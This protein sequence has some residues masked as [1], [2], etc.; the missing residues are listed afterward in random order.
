MEIHEAI[1]KR[2]SVRSY[3]DKSIPADI[4]SQ[5]N[6]E[7]TECNRESG[8]H[9][10]LVTG[11][12]EAF[13][14][15]M[16]HYGKF[17]GV[18]N[19]IALIGRKTADLDEK[20]GYYGERIAIKAQQLGLNTCW[21]AMTFSKKKSRCIVNKG[22]KL[23][24]VLSLGYGKTQGIAHKSKPMEQLCAVSGKMPEW[25]RKGMESVMLAPTAMNQQKFLFS[26]N[27]EN[28]TVKS[29]G[30]FYSKVDLGI[31]QYHFEVGSGRKIFGTAFHKNI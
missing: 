16:A 28:V 13:S 12:P 7:I 8:L 11:E 31:V 20:I 29:T 1:E 21:V 2:H 15:F 30:G 18:R 14:G 17:S 10:Q 26:L 25:F 19:Y 24:C 23:V 6:H 5:L 27:A 22:E 4:I 9:I 3:L